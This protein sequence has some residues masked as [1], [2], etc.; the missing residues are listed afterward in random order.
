MKALCGGMLTPSE[1]PLRYT[2]TQPVSVVVVGVADVG[3]LEENARVVESFEPFTAR[4]MRALAELCG[5][6]ASR[7]MYY[8]KKREFVFSLN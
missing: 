3:Q 8:K 4:D 2:L 1:I 7:L 6:Q 5:P